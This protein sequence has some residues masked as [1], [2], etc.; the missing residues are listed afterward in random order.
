MRRAQRQGS[1]YV[2]V[3]STLLAACA[4]RQSPTSVVG[5]QENQLRP[6]FWI[7]RDSSA[8]KKPKKRTKPLSSDS[9]KD[10]AIEQGIFSEYT[11]YI[12]R[13]RVTHMVH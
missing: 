5:V 13:T 11:L 8:N 12:I 7:A 10:P 2:F 6:E 3:A 9:P 1:F 4:S